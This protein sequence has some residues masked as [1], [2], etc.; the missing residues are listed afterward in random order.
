[1]ISEET[2]NAIFKLRGE[3]KTISEIAKELDISYGIVKY[4]T[5]KNSY[6]VRLK[7]N[8][9]F[10]LFETLTNP[11]FARFYNITR[12]DARALRKKYAPH[13]NTVSIGIENCKKFKELLD[14]KINSE[15]LNIIKTSNIIDINE[16]ITKNNCKQKYGFIKI[17]F[18]KIAI[19]NNI[20]NLIFIGYK[21]SH[22]LYCCRRKCDCEIGKLAN[23]I[24]AYFRNRSIKINTYTIDLFANQYL[25]NY[26]NDKS[27]QHKEF[28]KMILKEFENRPKESTLPTV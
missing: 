15:I 16:F 10:K 3:N 4:W 1:M 24:K 11:D 27:F 25:E 21:G 12:D 5:K 23:S 9:N 17:K 7:Y 13:T 2:A 19:D 28:Y 6:K 8:Y 26:K 18:E 14:R 20:T 22:G